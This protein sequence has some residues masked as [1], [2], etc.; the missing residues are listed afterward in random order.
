MATATVSTDD[1][2]ILFSADLEFCKMDNFVDITNLNIEEVTIFGVVV[3]HRKLPEPLLDRFYELANE[4]D[5]DDWE[6]Y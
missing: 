5:L 6:Q 3:D 4:I 2:G 1:V